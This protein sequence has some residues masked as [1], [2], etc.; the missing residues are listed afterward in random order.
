MAAR[1]ARSTRPRPD[2]L[3]HP[4][5]RATWFALAGAVVLVIA[6]IDFVAQ[7]TRSTRVEFFGASG[8]IPVAVALLVAAVAGAFVV[9]A[10]GIARTAHFRLAARREKKDDAADAPSASS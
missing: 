1:A 3:P 7:N 10:V 5:T 6:L 2:G 4:P 8:H 9:F